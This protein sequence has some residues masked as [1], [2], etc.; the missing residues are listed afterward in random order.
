MNIHPVQ[1]IE[2]KMFQLVN[3]PFYQIPRMVEILGTVV[4]R[5]SDAA[6]QE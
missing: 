6:E 3:L 1:T 2:G 4:R 5:Q